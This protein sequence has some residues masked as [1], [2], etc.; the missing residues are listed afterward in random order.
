MTHGFQRTPD[1]YR[2]EISRTIDAPRDVLWNLLTD[3]ARW[4]DWGPSI[5]AVDCRDRYIQRG[6]RGRV[7]V[8]GGIGGVWIPFRITAC[9]RYRWSWTVGPPSVGAFDLAPHVPATGHRIEEIPD[10]DDE[11]EA[12]NKTDSYRVVLEIP[13]LAAGYAIVCKRA[14]IK[15]DRIAAGE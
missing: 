9:A 15:L 3:T 8:V 14:L 6:A 11:Q 7:R 10:Q 1:G 13:P 12:K 4:S 5:K 2:I